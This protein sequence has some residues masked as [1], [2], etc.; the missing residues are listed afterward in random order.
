[1]DKQNQ[2]GLIKVLIIRVGNIGDVLMATP[3]CRKIKQLFPNAHIDFVVSPQAKHCLEGNAFI[4]RVFVLE[5]NK[6][7]HRKIR[8]F[9]LKHRLARERYD[10][11][12]ILEESP[13][14]ISFVAALNTHQ[15][16][17]AGFT[18]EGCEEKS[19]NVSSRNFVDT[20]VIKNNLA[21]VEKVFDVRIAEDD[22]A[23]DLCISSEDKDK[24]RQVLRGFVSTNGP[25]VVI[26]PGCMGTPPSRLWSNTQCQDLIHLLAKNGVSVFI[27]GKGEKEVIAV[28]DIYNGCRDFSHVI[29]PYVNKSFGHLSALIENAAAVVCMDTGVFHMARALQTPVVGLFGPSNPVHTGGIGRGEYRIIR[30]DFPC[31]PCNYTPEYNYAYKKACLPLTVPPCM[32]SIS[33]EQVYEAVKQFTVNPSVDK[34]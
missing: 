13:Q 5:K 15:G 1:M 26:H 7:L 8:R 18:K 31:G 12:F 17:V 23:M 21:L 14:Y 3:V 24:V 11:Y 30:N 29:W 34:E 10:Y 9:Y 25:Y 22:L 28:D 19:L 32:S 33:G 16:I 27:T 2:A 4:N 6:G 20:H